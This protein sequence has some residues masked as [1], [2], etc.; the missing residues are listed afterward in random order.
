M[1]FPPQTAKNEAA[2]GQEAAVTNNDPYAADQSSIEYRL[3]G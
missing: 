1:N 2:S 3:I